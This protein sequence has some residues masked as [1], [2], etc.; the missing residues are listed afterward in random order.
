MKHKSNILLLFFLITIFSCHKNEEFTTT[1]NVDDPPKITISTTHV[2]Q[3]KDE[4]GKAVDEFTS[5]VAGKNINVSNGN[6]AVF[7]SKLINKYGPC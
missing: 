7:E 6:I 5:T 2:I 3:V 4:N 1:E